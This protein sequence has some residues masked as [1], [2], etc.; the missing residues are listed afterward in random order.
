MAN[1]INRERVWKK[2]RTV[3]PSRLAKR[4]E[5]DLISLSMGLIGS[6]VGL[7]MLSIF[8]NPLTQD[9]PLAL[10][11]TLLFVLYWAV[12]VIPI[13]LIRQDKMSASDLG[14]KKEKLPNKDQLAV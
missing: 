9:M 2:G 14:F 1:E 10:R 6:F 13:I 3:S 7:C 5:N 12:A 4:R 11:A 8:L